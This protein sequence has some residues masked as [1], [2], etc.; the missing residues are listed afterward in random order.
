M[1][2]RTRR[3]LLGFALLGLGASAGS[4]Y[5]HY[6]LL[7][8]PGY[9]SFCDV[10][11]TVSCTE[12]YLSRYGSLL[13]VPVALLGVIWF[14]GAVLLIRAGARAYKP[15]RE[16]IVGY[17]FALST[18]GLA[19]VLYLAYASFVVL[20]AVC[21]LCVLTYV[22]VIG[23]FVVSGAAMSQPM[24]TLPRRAWRDLQTLA[25][26]PTALALTLALLA[27][28]ASAIAFFPRHTAHT[29]AEAAQ[30][31]A[32]LTD[33]QRAEFEAWYMALPKRDL[34]VGGGGAKVV[35]VKFTDYQCP[36][37]ANA[38]RSNR[39]VL[40]RYRAERPGAVQYL[41]RDFPLESEC[42]PNAPGGR[43]VA[44]CEAAVAVRLA[45]A[46]G[47]GERMEDWLYSNQ[48]SL[49][50]ATVRTAVREVAGVDDFE[51]RYAS[52]LEEVKADAAL[53]GLLGVRSTPTFFINGRQLPGGGLPPEYFDAA[54]AWELRQP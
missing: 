52:V 46:K 26:T 23:I 21:V 31:V 11:A 54:L 17:L 48:P 8:Q 45:R 20:Q 40:A 47:A 14:A 12:A 28:A 9:D 34:P 37:C 5:V 33:Q 18:V 39:P 1:T 35:V 41:T 36:A 22:A 32:P 19:F 44:A 30:P 6:Q 42:N 43:H 38:H 25:A 10:S 51:A 15:V 2:A 27:G 49:S 24:T 13:G 16:N 53:G 29:G 50:P 7:R 3:L 4:T